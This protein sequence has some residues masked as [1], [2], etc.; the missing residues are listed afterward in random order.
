M[1]WAQ[2]FTAVISV[3][4]ET[5]IRGLWFEAN[6]DKKLA[7]PHLNKQDRHGGAYVEGLN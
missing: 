1:G 2:W 6:P 3:T 7:R 4:P 5:E